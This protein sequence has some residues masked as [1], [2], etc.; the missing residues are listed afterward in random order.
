MIT[1]FKIYLCKSAQTRG[2]CAIKSYYLKCAIKG[3]LFLLF[4]IN[5]FISNGKCIVCFKFQSSDVHYCLA[6]TQIMQTFYQIWVS[7]LWRSSN[8]DPMSCL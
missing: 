6:L 5:T 7:V 1:K 4:T 8:P 3:F 2:K